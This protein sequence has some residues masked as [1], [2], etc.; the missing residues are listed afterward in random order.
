VFATWYVGVSELI[1]HTELRA[2][3]Q[4]GFDI[5]F[6]Q[7]DPSVFD[8]LSWHDFEIADLRVGVSA[9]VRF[10]EADDNI[11]AL[12]PEGV[13]VFEH[14]VGLADAWGGTDVDAE[15]RTLIGLEL[16]EHLLAGRSTPLWHRLMLLPRTR[17][18]C[19]SLQTLYDFVLTNSL[20]TLERFLTR[21]ARMIESCA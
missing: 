1:D 16:R 8:L 17:C 18:W 2:A 12:A 19:A 10:N 6:F 14:R 13:C 21:A 9:P 20:W 3:L 7:H 11:H 4:D 15:S 5:H